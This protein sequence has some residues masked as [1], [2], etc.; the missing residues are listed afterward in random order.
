MTTPIG[1]R[2]VL[3]RAMDRGVSARSACQL[4]GFSRSVSC[5]RLRQPAKDQPHVAQL[6]QTS[7]EYPRFGYRRMAFWLSLSETRVRRLWSQ[8]GL[9]L[10]RRRSRKRRLGTEVRVPGAPIPNSVWTY[11]FVHDRLADKT[12]LKLLCVLDEHTRECLAI[13]VA[14]SM[15][16]VTVINTLARLMRLH[17][18]P[19]FI[20]S[21]QGAEFTAGLVMR[22]L[23]DQNVG[24]VFIAAGKP[25]Q[26]GFV[27]SFNGKLRDECLSREWFRDLREARVLIERWREFYNHRRPH[28]ALGNR[29]PAA[30]RRDWLNPSMMKQPLTG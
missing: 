29:T 26:N 1:R 19:A 14:R 7:Q 21:D 25:W 5:Y 20:R 16:S 23:R 11:D 28:S 22:W 6:L 3:R 10:P 18:K 30:V 24:P 15:R 12:A 4:L 9:Q 17:G 27:E 13:E 8:Q 2:R